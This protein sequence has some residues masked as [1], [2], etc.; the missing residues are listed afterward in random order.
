MTDP[1]HQPTP[2]EPTRILRIDGGPAGPT[3]PPEAPA[4]APEPRRRHWGRRIVAAVVVIVLVAGALLGDAVAR[5]RTETEVAD[6][7][8]S[9]V[10]GESSSIGVDIGGWPFLTV[11]ATDRLDSVDITAPAATVKKDQQS[12]TF[13][14]VTIHASG[15]RNV[16]DID[17]TVMDSADATA[18]IT[19]KELSRLSG[20]TIT[21]AGGSRVQLVR[22]VKVLGVSVSLKISAA[23]SIR[24]EDRRI[25]FSKPQADVDGISVPST[26]LEPAVASISDRIDLPD[27]GNLKYQS[28]RADSRGLVVSLSGDAVAMKDLIGG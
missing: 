8:A 3:S 19:W 28:L 2:E 21:S 23:P 17:A 18:R 11:L 9:A 14:D 24:T 15:L 4:A 12:A 5:T 16:R 7:I 20:S 27:L 13:T 26:L 6:Q 1:H 10:G 22:S 25:V